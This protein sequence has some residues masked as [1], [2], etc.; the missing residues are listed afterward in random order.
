MELYSSEACDDHDNWHGSFAPSSRELGASRA[1]DANNKHPQHNDDYKIGLDAR[2]EVSN[3]TAANMLEHAPAEHIALPTATMENAASQ[4]TR[5]EELGRSKAKIQYATT[6]TKETTRTRGSASDVV[7]SGDGPLVSTM[8]TSAPPHCTLT[9]ECATRDEQHYKHTRAQPR[10][11]PCDDDCYSKF[12]ST[13]STNN[14][15]TIESDDADHGMASP[16]DVSSIPRHDAAKRAY[17]AVCIQQT[18]R[19]TEACPAN[20]STTNAAGTAT[21]TNER[22]ASIDRQRAR[23]ITQA[24]PFTTVATQH[25]SPSMLDTRRL[26][27]DETPK[28]CNEVGMNSACVPGGVDAF[29]I[30]DNLKAQAAS[31]RTDATA[32]GN[33]MAALADVC[34]PGVALPPDASF[35]IHCTNA[36]H[37]LNAIDNMLRRLADK[38]LQQSTHVPD[39]LRAATQLAAITHNMRQINE[40]GKNNAMDK[41]GGID[42]AC[43]QQDLKIKPASSDDDDN[44]RHACNASRTM[45]TDNVP[46]EAHTGQTNYNG[47][48]VA[49]CVRLWRPVQSHMS[50]MLDH[51]PTIADVRQR[52]DW[53][54]E[55]GDCI[56]G[57]HVTRSAAFRTRSATQSNMTADINMT[58]VST[59]TDVSG[60]D[61]GKASP[62]IGSSTSCRPQPFSASGNTRIAPSRPAMDD[63]GRKD[64]RNELADIMRRMYLSGAAALLRSALLWDGRCV[65]PWRPLLF[66][67]RTLQHFP[68]LCQPQGTQTSGATTKLDMNFAYADEWHQQGHTSIHDNSIT[69]MFVIVAFGDEDVHAMITTPT[70]IHGDARITINNDAGADMAHIICARPSS[71]QQNTTS[72]TLAAVLQAGID[73]ASCRHK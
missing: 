6:A 41:L 5:Q 34:D 71:R 38:G 48:H 59:T 21:T 14:I 13:T 31:K 52:A 17:L 69:Y 72:S 56:Y 37:A 26:I 32:F 24:S 57:D 10:Q 51:T 19:H 46:S 67:I 60:Y 11:Q 30:Q 70:N 73:R 47:Q 7:A 18:H 33:T 49:D 15:Q 63:S 44:A 61:L 54:G 4:W 65:R 2:Q 35:V 27:S 64:Q 25:M 66:W 23:M 22:L 68:R 12:E 29:R 43:P 50:T 55:D 20:G 45:T 1:T 53:Y 8:M 40:V 39:A 42:T 16:P 3:A 9:A 36:S 62:P 28:Q 58:T